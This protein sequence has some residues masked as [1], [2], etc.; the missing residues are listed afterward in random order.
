MCLF[1]L[2][3]IKLKIL[4]WIQKKKN[5]YYLGSKNDITELKLNRLEKRNTQWIKVN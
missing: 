3:I 5:I 1:N 2:L 4:I